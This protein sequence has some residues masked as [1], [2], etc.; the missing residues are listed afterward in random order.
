VWAVVV[1]FIAPRR[2][3]MASMPQAVLLLHFSDIE[4]QS[5]SVDETLTFFA[6]TS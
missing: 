5:C 2:D 3:E 6:G 4:I 1:K